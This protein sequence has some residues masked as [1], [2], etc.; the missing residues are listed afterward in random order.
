MRLSARILLTLAIAAPAAVPSTLREKAISA[1]A[2]P[3]I[4]L[5]LVVVGALG[6]CAEFCA[7][8]KIVPG[9][10]GGILLLLGLSAIAVLPLNWLGAA[11]F[12]LAL[13][14]LALEA[15]FPARGMLSAGAAIA[16]VL[17]AVMLIDGP[18]QSRIRWITALS[19]S[20]PFT[21]IATLLLKTAARARRNK[22]A[23]VRPQ[24]RQRS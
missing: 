7:P 23:D 4:A 24:P 16:M 6:I 1:V 18:P 3:N 9:V 12:L 20:L 14:L 10:L 5:I 13:P 21:C 2:D 22:A 11:L 8:G 19:V 15:R 17:G